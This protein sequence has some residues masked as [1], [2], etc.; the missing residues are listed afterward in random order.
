MAKRHGAEFWRRHLEAWH[1]SDFTQREYCALHGLSEKS[2]YR[3]RAKEKKGIAV[4]KSSLTLVPASVG[5]LVTSNVVRLHSPGGWKVELPS[6]SVAML[7][8][9]LRELP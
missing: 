6:V 4:A 5:A 3:W 1:G 9:L 8:D 2:F 7:V